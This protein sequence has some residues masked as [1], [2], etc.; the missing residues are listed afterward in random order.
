MEDEGLRFDYENRYESWVEVNEI[1]NGLREVDC[2][3]D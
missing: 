3:S 2:F 1:G